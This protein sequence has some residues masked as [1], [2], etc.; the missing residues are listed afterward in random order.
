MAAESE[1]IGGYDLA[2]AIA[3]MAMVVVNYSSMMQVGH[4]P[5]PWLKSAVE[6]LYGRAATLFIMLAGVSITLMARPYTSSS[7]GRVLQIRLLKRSLL[8]LFS[9]FALWIWWVADIL[10]FYA[11]YIAIGT[12]LV[13]WSDK[14]LQR[15]T[16]AVIWISM[17]V[18]ALLTAA[19][20]LGDLAAAVKGHGFLIRLLWDYAVSSNYSL[21]PWLSY[22]LFGMLIGRRNQN[23]SVFYKRCVWQGMLVCL[24]VELFSMVTLHWV[25]RQDWEIEGNFWLAFLRSDAFPA[26]PLFILSSGGCAVALIGL[27]RLVYEMF[28]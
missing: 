8:L 4:Y 28:N 2:R 20:D 14:A 27:C 7:T 13:S 24:F 18:S 22:F 6:F 19:Y 23:G 17:P 9:G 3:V 25:S 5:W 15:L 10:H 16:L 12:G 11:L 1:R 26:T 21:L